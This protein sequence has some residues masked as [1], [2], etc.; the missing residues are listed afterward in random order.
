MSLAL[1]WILALGALFAGLLSQRVC[2]RLHIP[3]APWRY[4]WI[5]LI[6]K[7]TEQ[8]LEAFHIPNI[9]GIDF[10]VVANIV[11]AVATSRSAIW[12]LLELL[13]RLRLIPSS[14]KILRDLLF[15]IC[16]GILIALTLQEQSSIDLVGLVTTSAVLTAVL[17]L[18]A[19]DP[20]KDL[21]GGLSLQLERVIREGDWVEIEGQIGRVESISWRDTELNC[22]YGSRLT[23]PHA[24]TNSKSIR[25]FT[26]NGS[27]ATKLEIGLDYNMPPHIAKSIMQRISKHHPLVLRDP[28]CMIRIKSFE[29][30]TVNYEWINWLSDYGQTRTLRGDLQE[31]LWY[32]LQREG[33]S[34]PYSVRDVRLT[35]T[36]QEHTE[37]EHPDTAH[38]KRITAELLEK[39]HLFSILSEGQITKLIAM[40]SIRSYG[41]GEIIA[42]QQESGD[43]LFMLI[44]GQV[45]IIKANSSE[46]PTEVAKL[47]NGDICGEMTVFTDAPRS[48]TIRSCSQSDILEIDRQAIAELVDEEPVLL[49]R[50]SQLISERQEKL[51]NL[52]ALEAQ[53]PSARRDVLGRVKELFDT[54]LTTGK[55]HLPPG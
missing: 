10:T 11:V 53:T 29:E 9:P 21:V 52:D 20:L 38:L 41:P 36:V 32:A 40:S 5:A 15:I 18:A 33:F 51:N 1:Q 37:A 26:T 4:A 49:E 12:L 44:D 50:F 23:L 19:Q 13:P 22:L 55:G 25:N 45:S 48:A 39:N 34:F 27:Y 31:Q 35:N 3:Q 24:H 8:S 30:S 54:L 7:A 16:S 43:S 46:Q 47:L 42:V 28:A 17:G 2:R 6:A 14:P